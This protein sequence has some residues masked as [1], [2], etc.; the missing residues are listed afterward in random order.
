MNICIVTSDRRI[1]L[2]RCLNSI[3]MS[4][5]KQHDIH[6]IDD[7]SNDSTRELLQ[8]Y[9]HRKL[10]KN[11]ILNTTKI[12]SAKSF[13]TI[14]DSTQGEWVIMTCDDMYFH[15][16]WDNAI[17]TTAKEQKDCGIV[18][19]FN[20]RLFGICEGSVIF[21]DTLWKSRNTGL[22]SALLYRELYEKAGKFKIN[23][24]KLMGF[25]ARPF[26]FRANAVQ[27]KRNVHYSLR[28]PYAIHMGEPQC[29]LNEENKLKEYEKFRNL[30]KKGIV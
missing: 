1:Y 10:I 23:G 14:I 18:T 13:N 2:E 3:I 29:I 12:G 26:C 30:H 15:R 9:L 11:V 5:P 21:N 8:E 6:V 25:F 24:D 20:W 27:I 7:C 16:G 28:T 22:G 17:I 19:F 4:A